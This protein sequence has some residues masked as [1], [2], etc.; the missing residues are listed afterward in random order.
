MGSKTSEDG[1]GG[2]GGQGGGRSLPSSALTN[3]STTTLG[4]A[5]S[6]L[7]SG[8]AR[9]KTALGGESL[10]RFPAGRSRPRP[11]Y[12]SAGTLRDTILDERGEALQNNLVNETSTRPIATRARDGIVQAMRPPG[13]SNVRL[14]RAV[15]CFS[16]CFADRGRRCNRRTGVGIRKIDLLTSDVC[17]PGVGWKG[18]VCHLFLAALGG[19]PLLLP[20]RLPR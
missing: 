7:V 8:C 20:G 11:P 13:R 9:G 1:G 3:P 16:F 5:V 6:K 4:A 10:G 17:V 12:V 18:G 2:R 15:G 19:W 14:Q